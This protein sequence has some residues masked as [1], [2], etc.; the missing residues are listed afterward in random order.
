ML[1]KFQ[2][3]HHS[4]PLLEPRIYVLGWLGILPKPDRQGLS[5]SE[6]IIRKLK[7]SGVRPLGLETSCFSL[8]VENTKVWEPAKFSKE[9]SII[10]K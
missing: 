5:D 8:H 10:R 1:E 7:E 3:S 6:G 9:R 4:C 2:I